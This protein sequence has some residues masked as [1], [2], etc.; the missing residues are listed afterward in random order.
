M[1]DVLHP[2]DAE[3]EQEGTETPLDTGDF[4][5]AATADDP[6]LAERLLAACEDAGIPALLQSPRS[7][8]VGTVASP[9]EGWEIRVPAEHRDR[10]A[11]LLEETKAALA[12]DPE[13]A[14][15]AAEEEEAA[16]E[17]HREG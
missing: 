7:G 11:V 13:G 15:R 16:S 17:T 8:P 9:V 14:G 10:A 12:A 4:Q 3:A 6:I 2:T 5:L 1:P